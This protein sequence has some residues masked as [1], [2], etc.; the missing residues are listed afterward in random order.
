MPNG[1][2]LYMAVTASL[3]ICNSLVITIIL[4][5]TKKS[6]VTRHQQGYSGEIHTRCKRING[7]KIVDRKFP[8]L[9]ELLEGLSE[10]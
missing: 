8:N 3:F 5:V 4:V 6:Y 2:I 7:N 9:L 10:S 1:F